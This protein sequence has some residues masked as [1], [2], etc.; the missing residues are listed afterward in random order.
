[1]SAPEAWRIV[2]PEEW[3]QI[4]ST[5]AFFGSPLDV[6]DGYIHMSPPQAVRET[7]QRYFGGKHATIVLLRVDLSKCAATALRWDWVESRQTSFPHLYPVD[8][9]SAQ[10]PR[11]AV[12]N[13]YTLAALGDSFSGFP[14][15]LP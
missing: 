4:E 13:V 11:E 9:A 1:M 10:L 6:K 3:V 12:T 7:A 15:D 14:S 2:L 8:G 5:G